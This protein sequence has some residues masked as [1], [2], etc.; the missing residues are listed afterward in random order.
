MKKMQLEIDHL[1][2]TIKEKDKSV[3]QLE[4]QKKELDEKVRITLKEKE[5]NMEISLTEKIAQ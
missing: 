4:K 5:K 3:T 1:K 2:T